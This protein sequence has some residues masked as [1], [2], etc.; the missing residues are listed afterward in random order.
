VLV[1]VHAVPTS[2]AIQGLEARQTIEDIIKQNCTLVGVERLAWKRLGRVRKEEKVKSSLIIGVQLEEV[3]NMLFNRG[4]FLGGDHYLVT[5]HETTFLVT[6]C[7]KCQGFNHIA[8][9]C[10]RD[11]R[12]GRCAGQYNTSDC[13]GDLPKK[14]INCKADHEA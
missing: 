7:F 4:L 5:R 11:A 13:V 1:E 14:C 9:S 2:L 8:K 3:A 6:Q 12:C 10:R